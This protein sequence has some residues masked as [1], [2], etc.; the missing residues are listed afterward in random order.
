MNFLISIIIT[1]ILLLVSDIQGIAVDFT[2]KN[3]V[4]NHITI[5]DG[6][7]NNRVDCMIQDHE[8][9]LW[10]GTKRGLCR[11]NGYEFKTYQSI[12]ND[13][14]SLR[15]HQITSLME[16]SDGTLWIG[17]WEGGLHKYNREND[18]F[19]RIHLG[20]Q[21]VLENTITT[22]FEDSK[23]GIW[24][25]SEDKLFL[26]KNDP[27]ESFEEVKSPDGKNPLANVSSIYEDNMGT[28]FI[29]SKNA[30][31]L[32]TYNPKLNT[33]AA[34]NIKAYSGIQPVNI[35]QIFPFDDNNLWI[36]A[37]N[38]LFNYN[39]ESRE[40]NFVLQNNSPEPGT[41][42]N[43]I[44]PA[45]DGNLWLGGEGLYLY[46]KKEKQFKQFSHEEGNSKTIAGNIITCCFE[47][48]Q[49]NLWFGTFNKGI[50]VIYNK[51]K[52]FNQNYELSNKLEKASKN[53]TAIYKNKEEY[54][55][56]GTWDKGLLILDKKNQI[57]QTAAKFSGLNHLRN[58][59]IRLIT[60]DKN[61]II[62]IGSGNN[63][64]TRFDSRNNQT[65][66]YRIP[67]FSDQSE[68]MI[69]SF[70]IDRQNRYWVANPTGVFLFEPSAGTFTKY[71]QNANI[72]NLKEDNHGNI[73]CA[74]YN[75]GLCRINVDNSV[76]YFKSN[77][78]NTNLP[79]NKFVCLFKDS[80]GRMWV[81][82]EFNGLFLYL[83]DSTRFQLFTVN[84]GLPSNDICSILEDSKGRLWIGT[85]NGLSRFNYSLKDFSNY[86][87]SDGMN[88]DEFHYNSS[89][90]SESGELYFG[91]TDGIVFFDPDDIR[92]NYLPIPLKLED[93][94]VNYG[95]VTK[96]LKGVS[97]K[98][99]L[100]ESTPFQLKYN[101]NTILFKYTTLNYCEAK[102]SNFAYQLV[103]LDN[104]F[105]YVQNQ[106]QVT[107]S[108]LKPGRYIFRVIASNN[109]NIWDKK[110]TEIAFQI[111]NPPWLAWWAYII[112]GFLVLLL[113]Y[114][115]RYQ[116]KHEE[117]MK[118]AVRVERIEK[119]Q[120]KE[121]NQM[122][123]QFFTNIS[124]EFKT[125]LTLIIGP[126]EQI[127]SELHGNS[128]LKTKLKQI[129]SN[130]KR[131]LELINQL[132][133]FRK[134]EQD[135]LPLEKTLNNLVDTVQKMMDLFN[136]IAIKSE[137]L[138]LLDSDFEALNFNFDRDK[139]E[140]ILSNLLS[141]SFKNTSGGGTISIRIWQSDETK[142]YISISDTGT[143]I[144]QA[145]VKRIFESF[146]NTKTNSNT[147][148]LEMQSS[149]IGLAYS[150]KLAELHKGSLQIESEVNKGTTVTVE[151]PYDR[152]LIPNDEHRERI[153]QSIAGAMAQDS[154]LETSPNETEMRKWID[155]SLSP[156]ILVVEDDKELR[157]YIVS[158]LMS[159]YQ[160]DEAEDGQIGYE[161][162]L[163]NDYD[164]IVSDVMM[165]NMSGIQLCQKIKSNIKTSHILVILLTVRSDIASITEGYKTGAD[166]YLTK[167]FM[168]ENL[169]QVIKNLLNTR[170]HIKDFYTSTDENN[171]E[172]IGIHPHDKQFIA[173]TINIIEKNINEEKFS[174]EVLGKALG[175]SRTHLFRK[176][177]SLTG[178]APN[179]FIRQIRIKKAAQLIKEGNYSVSEVCYMVGF[180]T[181]ANFSTSFKAFYGKSPKE[182]QVK[183]ID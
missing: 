34:L 141:N 74:N 179:D 21:D 14:T 43:F 113:L 181:P 82:T 7:P 98:R 122:K 153:T 112:Y 77:G 56:I 22:L 49:K 101:Q 119:N 183:K 47:D 116:L 149:G 161:Q 8:G 91:C 103:G 61:D 92:D 62:W 169:I 3:V 108:N 106:R 129:S 63:I 175:L 46:N 87:R 144:E 157:K 26:V 156:R 41:L 85:N 5:E 104:D 109:D 29:A 32:I 158:I 52:F 48:N 137:I 128:G 9:Y 182:F 165:P 164:L 97:I 57:I 150:K 102:K 111:K 64:L 120:Q 31:A 45:V 42:F 180:K 39:K 94:S 136:P 44:R 15:Y 12:L 160:I 147:N 23:K 83:P 96:D 114:A 135:V 72:Q 131:L 86:V 60:A 99:D 176:F 107:Y 36:A 143:G 159:R 125:P 17:T 142:V 50:N 152:Q 148:N 66:I 95:T 10:F 37:S 154:S 167:P 90:K 55:F 6:L 84:D 59:V 81:G 127:I 123:L 145:K 38:G 79:D 40:I 2:S 80:K 51:T 11:Y 75:G 162:A 132:I 53:I 121:L 146:S 19:I 126:L 174:V 140:K 1:T 54:L 173:D 168:P 124:H 4:F 76:S 118:T 58:T 13:S 16:S 171:K 155:T 33:T 130:S 178:I 93:I 138:F 100:E 20:S 172:P 69:T 117:M 18:N 78:K 68:S 35:N 25:A 70:L 166:S 170:Q 71:L 110:G 88:A 30:A 65:K 27:N 89:F 177:K 151:L 105:N 115:L 133:D 163:K 134:I 73:W 28:I 139:M 67:G 24:V